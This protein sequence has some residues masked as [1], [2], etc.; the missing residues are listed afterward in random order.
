[1]VASRIQPDLMI[2]GTEARQGL[3][4][5]FKTS[6]AEVIASSI[7][8]PTLF[9]SDKSVGFVDSQTGELNLGH[10]M[11]P[12]GGKMPHQ[13]TVDTALSLLDALDPGATEITFLHAGTARDDLPVFDLPPRLDR[14]WKTVF[15]PGRIVPAILKAVT[16]LNP[17]LL[18]MSTQ[19]HRRWVDDLIG[20]KTE[21]VM[22]ELSVPVV[23]VPIAENAN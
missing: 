19:G 23:A 8:V 5:Y 9:L 15:E 13:A 17:N 2:L 6:V 14:Y 22:R 3:K 21:R 12:I 4:Q 10:V 18:I 1:M 7:D 20:S 11:V 16:D